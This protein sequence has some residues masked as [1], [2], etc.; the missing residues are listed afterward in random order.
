MPTRRGTLKGIGTCGHS[1]VLEGLESFLEIIGKIDGATVK[2]GRVIGRGAKSGPRLSINGTD[3]GF[4]ITVAISRGRQEFR[5]LVQ[6]PEK[7]KEIYENIV[8]AFEEKVA[9]K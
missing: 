7:R 9:P 4:D 3:T 2:S 1:T 8:Q 5:V 6:E